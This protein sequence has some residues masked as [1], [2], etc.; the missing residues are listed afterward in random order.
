M[1]PFTGLCRLGRAAFAGSPA[2]VRFED[3][4]VAYFAMASLATW[5]CRHDGRCS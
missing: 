2:R 1:Q 3:Y 5:L 4:S